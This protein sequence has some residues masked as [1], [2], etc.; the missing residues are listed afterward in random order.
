MP[1]H[2]LKRKPSRPARKL[3]TPTG[4]ASYLSDAFKRGPNSAPFA[5]VTAARSTNMVHLTRRA[6][7]SRSNLYRLLSRERGD[8]KLRTALRLLDALGMKLEVKLKRKNER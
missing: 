8:L 5:I 1:K 4:V 7:L 3:G 2:K 6:N